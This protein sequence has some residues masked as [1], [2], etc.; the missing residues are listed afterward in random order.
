MVNWGHFICTSW[1]QDGRNAAET[2]S[3]EPLSC[4]T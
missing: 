3:Q 1:P 4:S 2:C